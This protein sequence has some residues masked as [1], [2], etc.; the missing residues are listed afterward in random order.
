M[1][2]EGFQVMVNL[3]TLVQSPGVIATWH[4]QSE[5]ACFFFP[6]VLVLVLGG[7]LPGAVS[8]LPCKLSAPGD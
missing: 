8:S 7:C 4:L 6:V 5:A 3:S 1:D 2:S